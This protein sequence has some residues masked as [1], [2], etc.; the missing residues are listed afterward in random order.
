MATAREIIVC[1]CAGWLLVL[2]FRIGVYVGQAF[3]LTGA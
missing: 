2:A 3:P 1:F